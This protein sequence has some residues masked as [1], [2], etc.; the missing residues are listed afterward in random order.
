M[1]DED[2]FTD[3]GNQLTPEQKKEMMDVDVKEHYEMFH[4]ITSETPLTDEEKEFLSKIDSYDGNE[5]LNVEFTDTDMIRNSKLMNEMTRLYG[6]VNNVDCVSYTYV[7]NVYEKDSVNST[8]KYTRI[9]EFNEN[10]TS[11]L[12]SLFTHHGAAF[13]SRSE[14]QCFGSKKM[15]DVDASGL[16]MRAVL[17]FDLIVPT[18]FDIDATHYYHHSHITCFEPWTMIPE[19]WSYEVSDGFINSDPDRRYLTMTPTSPHKIETHIAVYI[20][21]IIDKK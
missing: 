17:V 16:S 12:N 14:T 20:G 4:A 9:Y 15:H 11:I 8:F 7:I 19:H 18:G 2:T 13:I 6:H 21:G 3:L 1:K 10:A 5:D